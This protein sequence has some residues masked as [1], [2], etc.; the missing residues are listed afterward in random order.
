MRVEVLHQN[1]VFNSTESSTELILNRQMAQQPSQK[2][3]NQQ[4]PLTNKHTSESK[5]ML[6]ITSNS[7]HNRATSELLKI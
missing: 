7:A 6:S 2:K 1:G 4:Q 5:E 3:R